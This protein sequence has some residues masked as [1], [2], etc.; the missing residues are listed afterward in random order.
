MKNHHGGVILVGDHVYGHSNNVGWV[1]QDFKSGKQVWKEKGKLGKGA[2]AFA[3]GK[4]Y[5][6]S[7]DEGDV[8]LIDA[9]PEGWKEHGRFRL[10]PQTK[11]RKPSGRIWTHPVIVDGKLFLRDQELLFCFDVQ[12]R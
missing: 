6:L 8:V 11:L 10:E 1:C 2:I 12:Q 7:E 5:C 3:D 4:F 9:S